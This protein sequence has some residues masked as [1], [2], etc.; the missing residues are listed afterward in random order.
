V[1]INH[2]ADMPNIQMPTAVVGNKAIMTSSIIRDNPTGE[3]AW[4]ELE[5]I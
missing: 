2:T 3:C 4:G 1:A 5:R